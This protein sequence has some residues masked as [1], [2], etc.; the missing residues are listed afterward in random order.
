MT[1]H[2]Y[3]MRQRLDLVSGV[4]LLLSALAGTVSLELAGRQRYDARLM[5]ALHEQERFVY[6]LDELGEPVIAARVAQ[7]ASTEERV[8]MLRDG[9]M[10]LRSNLRVLHTGGQLRLSEGRLLRVRPLRG[11]WVDQGLQAANAWIEPYAVRLQALSGGSSAAESANTVQRDFLQHR[12]EL[13]TYLRGVVAIA[14]SQSLEQVVR[15]SFLQ[16]VLMCS[17][18]GLFLMGILVIRRLVTT[19]LHRMA[20]GIA[21]MR[22][23]GRLVKLP[24]PHDNELGIVAAGFNQLAQHVEEQKAR[25]RD[26]IVELQRVNAELDRLAHVKDDFLATVNHQLRTPLTTLVEGVELLRDGVVGPLTEDQMTLVRTMDENGER[27]TALVEDILDLIMLRS[28]RRPLARQPND[29]GV[30]LRRAQA[31]WQPVSNARTVSLTCG[32][33]PPVYIDPQAIGEVLDH[34]L[35]NALRH[36]PEQSDVAIASRVQ[37]GFV[38]VTVKDHGPGMS[39]EQ[40]TRLFQPF[41]HLHTPDAPGSQGNGLG[42]AFC[43]QVVERHRGKIWAES[44]AGQGT[45]LTFTLPVASPYF[46][47]E[48]ACEMAREMARFEA[49]QFA[50]LVVRPEADS[51][52]R[53]LMDDVAATLRKHTHRNDAFV[54]L[55]ERTLAILA[56]TDH[57]GLSAMIQRLQK[58]LTDASARVH[59]G[60]ALYPFA[61]T[62]HGQ[63]FAHA[64]Q[65]LGDVATGAYATMPATHSTQPASPRA[66]ARRRPDDSPSGKAQD[67]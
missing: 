49:G 33:L 46:L 38:E 5:H 56:V 48:E 6:E 13:R 25:L 30:V 41:T 23:T 35:R 22:T 8:T 15:L 45:T 64:R 52:A 61:G 3:S 10:R 44:S 36:A 60:A 32:E 42:L 16:L 18:I 9:L 29:L 57:P 62:T 34:L 14:E 24:V 17:G 37:E 67:A 65:S 21:A 2:S 4:L 55:D 11:R 19:P 1:P 12:S 66:D 7:G 54:R 31:I 28:G 51:P 26:H 47:F 20:D 39:A 53:P 59:I 43:H 58:V 27:L 40:L 63:L 50:L